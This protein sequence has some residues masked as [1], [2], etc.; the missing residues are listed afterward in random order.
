MPARDLPRETLTPTDK[1][2][3]VLEQCKLKVVALK[4][5]GEE[6]V[7][8]LRLMDQAHSLFHE[9]EAKGSDLRAERSRWETIGRQLDSCATLLVREV[10]KAGGLAQLREATE[11]TADRWWWFLDKKVRRQRRRSFQRVLVGGG[12]V[13]VI[14]VIASL[15]YQRFIA[16]DPLTR[17]A[18]E[19][20]QR[21]EQAIQEG[22]METALT[23]YKG[24]NELTPGDPEVLLQLGVLYEILK[25]NKDATQAYARA[26][27][28]MMDSQ[29]DF[30]IARGIVYLE[31]G[32]WESAQVDAQAALT[33]NPESALGY[34]IAGSA[35]EAQGQISEAVEAWSQSADL[36]FTQKNDTLY[37]LIKLRLGTLMGGS[38][39]RGP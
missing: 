36:A 22:E 15:L 31:M 16:P 8:F 26:R 32:Q 39:G 12:T 28:L 10:Q 30:F 38:T 21:A 25:Q 33:L 3:K 17:Q 34:F 4:G 18:L 20:N 2:R 7:D 6:A 11:P 13:L 1:L 23:E 5:S 37:A 35:Y 19:F 9:I 29:E 27:E 24:L 14:L